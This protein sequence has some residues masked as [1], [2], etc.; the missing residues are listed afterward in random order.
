M[1]KCLDYGYVELFDNFPQER[2]GSLEYRIVEA[3]RIS[4]DGTTRDKASDEK[5]IRYLYN[6]KHTSPFEHVMF[7]FK[8]KCPIFV[9]RQIM[10][11][12]TA[13]INEFSQR[14]SEVPEQDEYYHLTNSDMGIRQ[15]HTV[16]KQSSTIIEDESLKS[17]VE[18]KLREVEAK[19]NMLFKDYHELIDMGVAKETARFCLPVATYTKF[20]WTIDLHNLIHFLSLRMH[21]HAQYETRVFAEAIFELI[22][23]LVP[24]TCEL[25]SKKL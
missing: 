14:Y 25:L 2:D 24:V 13:K 3:A 4:T 22:K 1:V 11:H 17:G 16:N 7:T 10:R 12:R 15:A 20:V 9:A 19:M 6:N 5:L 23:N 8:I 18:T 21:P